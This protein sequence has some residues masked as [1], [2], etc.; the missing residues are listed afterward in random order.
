MIGWIRKL[1]GGRPASPPPAVSISAKPAAAPQPAVKAETAPASAVA[2]TPPPGRE[3]TLAVR[4]TLKS[5][6]RASTAP[7]VGMVA[8]V[9]APGKTVKVTVL[10]VQSGGRRVLAKQ[11]G[12]RLVQAFTLRPDQTYRLAGASDASVTQLLLEAP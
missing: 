1:F 12:G 3:G 2:Q 11:N 8:S 7:A 5:D 4:R 6:V 9:I 10:A